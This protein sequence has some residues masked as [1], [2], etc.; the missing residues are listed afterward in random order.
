MKTQLKHTINCFEQQGNCHVTSVSFY[1]LHNENETCVDR[2]KRLGNFY[3]KTTNTVKVSIHAV[4][5]IEVKM[6]W[7]I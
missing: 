7:M 5:T 4:L 6:Y 1:S 2:I 3:S